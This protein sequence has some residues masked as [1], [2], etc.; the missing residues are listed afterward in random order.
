M[1]EDFEARE[2]LVSALFTVL[3]FYVWKLN[4]RD[5]G[6]SREAT[7]ALMVSLVEAVLETRSV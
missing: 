4:R 7:E 2:R 3:D 1:T 5:L 6:K